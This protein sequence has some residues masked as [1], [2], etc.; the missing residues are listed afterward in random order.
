MSELPVRKHTNR[1]LIRIDK[2]HDEEGNVTETEDLIFEPGKV[3]LAE[4][5]AIEKSNHYGLTWPQVTA[6]IPSGSAVA[7]AAVIWVLHK[8]SN[9][10]LKPAEEQFTIGS[11]HV[12]DP[13]FLP[14]HGGIP[15]GEASGDFGTEDV[16]DDTP[17][18]KA[19]A[20]R[21]APRK[22]V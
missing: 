1:Y 4:A 20:R 7:T 13:D 10:A 16:A 6:G 9:P 8:R 18:A 17:K 11:V 14:E 2:A 21:R 19:P 22:A 3:L 15:L 5:I 12:M